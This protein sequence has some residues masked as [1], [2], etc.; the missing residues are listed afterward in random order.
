MSE[1][2]LFVGGPWDGEMRLM[3]HAYPIYSVR[4]HR[5]FGFPGDFKAGAPIVNEYVRHADYK[6]LEIA[7]RAFYLIEPRDYEVSLATRD[8]FER[9]V[10]KLTRGYRRV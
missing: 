6:R 3:E 9:L 5:T 2:A 7:G 8:P 1:A 4:E 10:D